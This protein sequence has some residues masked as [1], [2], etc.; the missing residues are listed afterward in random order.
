MSRPWLIPQYCASAA[1]L[2]D[3]SAIRLDGLRSLPR[4][5]ICHISNWLLLANASHEALVSQPLSAMLS[6]PLSKSS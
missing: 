3:R 4:R 1:R 5:E 2:K 6:L